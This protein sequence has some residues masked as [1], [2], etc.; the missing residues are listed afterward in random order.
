MH[1]EEL[2]ELGQMTEEQLREFKTPWPQ[3]IEELN[4]IIQALVERQHDYG[5][6]VYAMSI[7]AVAA[8]NFVAH[9]LGTTGFQAGCADL[10]IVR[11]NRSLKGPFGSEI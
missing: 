11:R 5:T 10:D 6:C 4:D 2:K 7:A 8:Y 1:T 9:K 3:S